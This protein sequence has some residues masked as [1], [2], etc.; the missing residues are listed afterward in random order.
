MEAW[1]SRC[2]QGSDREE[3][4]DWAHCRGQ[5]R[6]LTYTDTGRTAM[7]CIALQAYTEKPAPMFTLNPKG[8]TSLLFEDNH[9]EDVES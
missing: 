5:S 4:S 1:D 3:I 7:H 2:M 9:K 6:A 8:T